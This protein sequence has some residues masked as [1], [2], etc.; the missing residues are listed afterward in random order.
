MSDLG[1]YPIALRGHPPG[2]VVLFG[3]LD[4]L[5][6]SGPGWA[7]FAILLVGAS[8]VTAVLM[9]VR[10][11]AGEPTARRAAPFVVLAPA[12]IWIAT[13]TDA[14]TMGTA[15]WVVALLVFAGCRR[16]RI[17]DVLA[18][19]AGLLAAFVALQS[20]GLVLLALPILV[21]AIAQRRVRPALISAIVAPI[22][23][24]SLSFV[25]YSWFDGLSATMHEYHTLDLDRPYVPFLVIN[26]AAWA[27]GARAGHGRRHGEGTRSTVVVAGR[28]RPS[29]RHRRERQRAVER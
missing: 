2:F 16:D 22:V 18:A 15:A 25:G 13:S 21:I 3:L 27:L 28:W 1:S 20:Y 9:T 7:A 11:V 17:G 14:L 4:R 8:G 24:L 12:A 23:T 6:L 19:S 29:G 5:G 10:T 26:L